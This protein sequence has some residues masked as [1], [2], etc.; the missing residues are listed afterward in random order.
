MLHSLRL[1][2]RRKI[3]QLC[4]WYIERYGYFV[5]KEKYLYPWQKFIR[6]D[7][8]YNKDSNLP[9]GALEYLN[10]SNPRLKELKKSYLN[11]IQTNHKTDLWLDEY[12]I[13]EHLLYFRGD[14]PY[15]WQKRG[16]NLNIMAYAMTYFWIKNHDK[17]NLLSKFVEDN[18]FGVQTFNFN[19]KIVSRDLLD[20]INEI[21]FLNKHIFLK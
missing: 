4:I 17:D 11:Y 12:V 19:G 3:K 15:V 7:S 16:I 5:I 8:S 9:D 18:S 1:Y 21:K 13:D 20:S 14:N 6:F 2:I 10:K